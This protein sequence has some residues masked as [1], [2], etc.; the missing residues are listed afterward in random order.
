MKLKKV[1][2]TALLAIPLYF[3]APSTSKAEEPDLKIKNID[4]SLS[5]IEYKK[6]SN[7]FND[8]EI[9]D[10]IPNIEHFLQR[11]NKRI[12]HKLYEKGFLLN[13]SPE[14]NHFLFNRSDPT[15]FMNDMQKQV[16][17]E[18]VNKDLEKIFNQQVRKEFQLEFKES[19]CY[20]DFKEDTK[21]YQRYY[22]QKAKEFFTGKTEVVEKEIYINEGGG[23]TFDY[24]KDTPP[25]ANLK[26]K[27][28]GREFSLQKG[29]YLG[30]KIK[31]SPFSFS[32][33]D[34]SPKINL[35]LALP[36]VYITSKVQYKTLD[37]NLNS[38]LTANLPKGFAVSLDHNLD[39]KDE[40][41][42]FTA[43]LH[44]NIKDF[45]VSLSYSQTRS[46]KDDTNS[47]SKTV[48]LTIQKTW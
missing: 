35:D 8:L 25:D 28:R 29:D 12:E 13:I 17:M 7:I 31:A 9:T 3:L 34:Y 20:N 32:N 10:P 4:L 36:Y 26:L 19:R 38:G 22:K 44:K 45:T 42:S 39:F 14:T 23:L 30:F 47:K 6:D 2:T 27:F 18:K 5:Q 33:R 24:K 46:H 15:L 43:A 37:Q 40:N 48:M 41:N 16:Y 11:V 1:I 21:Y